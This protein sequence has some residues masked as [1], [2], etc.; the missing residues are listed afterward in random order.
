MLTTPRKVTTVIVDRLERRRNSLDCSVVA[1]LDH[2][3]FS[4]GAGPPVRK[5]GGCVGGCVGWEPVRNI[6]A[7]LNHW[8]QKSVSRYRPILPVALGQILGCSLSRSL[9]RI[10]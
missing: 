2:E 7:K 3:D 8:L 4:G 10:A 5:V 1:E 9:S 6:L